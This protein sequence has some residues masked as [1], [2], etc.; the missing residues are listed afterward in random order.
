MD[1]TGS[2][3]ETWMKAEVAP[4]RGTKERK[5]GKMQNTD[6]VAWTKKLVSIESTNPGKEEHE[7]AGFLEREIKAALPEC[8]ELKKDYTKEGRPILMA[9]LP[10][11][12][13]EE[14][15]LICHMDTVPIAGGW[16]KNPLGEDGKNGRFFGRGSCDMK[17]GL[18]ASLCAFLEAA[19]KMKETGETSKRTVKWLGTCDEEGDMT[20]AERVI[21]LG[22]VTKDS[23]VMDTEPTDGE[24]QT[25]HKGRCWFEVTMHGRAAHASRPEQGMDAIAGMAYMLAS[26]RNRM[27]ELKEDPFLGKST[28]VFGEIQGGIHP[29]QVPAKCKVSVDIRAVPP[30]HIEDMKAL[31]QAAAEDAKKEI[32]GL[33]AEIKITGNRPPIAHYEDA[34]MLARMKEAVEQATGKVP[35]VSAFP[36]YTDTAVIA[37]TTG[38]CNCLSYGPGTLAMAHKADEYVDEADIVR[39]RNVY[40]LLLK[41]WLWK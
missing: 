35:V 22:W 10:G 41:N 37:G 32:F 17:S 24:I 4:G 7:I 19:T 21:E 16:T 8:G 40:D 14:L 39:C 34:E 23:F 31:L 38:N 30:Y 18:A 27:K 1:M 6:A 2:G 25:A 13:K 20:G 36:G 12:T 26:A 5:Q 15:V 33:R 9:V 11:E 28:I 29:Y 3:S